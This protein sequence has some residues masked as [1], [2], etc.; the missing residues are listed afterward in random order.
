MAAIKP[1][2]LVLP[3][4]FEA[5]QKKAA[6]KR[7]IAEM[8][9]AKSQQ[10][11]NMTHWTQALAS[12]AQAGVGKHLDK[13]ADNIELE[14]GDRL[15][16]EY[17]TKLSAFNDATQDPNV[18]P[19]S[20]V[21]QFGADPLLADKTKPYADA[22][23]AGLRDRNESTNFGGQWR[24]KGDIKPGEFEPGRPT[25][26]V[27]RM[28]NGDLATNDV[29][30]VAALARQGAVG[31]DGR[32]ISMRAPDPS[33][34]PMPQQQG[35]AAPVQGAPPVGGGLDLNLLT[36]EEKAIMQKEL[37]RRAGGQGGGMAGYQPPNPN[38]PMGSPLSASPAPAGMTVDG[39][40]Y[41]LV[42][43][44]PYDNPEGK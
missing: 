24:R 42:N 10:G 6:R 13:K 32:P 22:M 35:M 36:P 33:R 28:S 18:D 4:G 2:A 40:P 37:A 9:L 16:Q 3:T 14:M 15:K 34:A 23:A 43:G 29:A 20:V 8:M 17:A 19:M 44:V 12:V 30:T 26:G 25:D 1:P 5:D 27:L 38:V 31:A 11:G 7:K 39:K 21:R 41:W